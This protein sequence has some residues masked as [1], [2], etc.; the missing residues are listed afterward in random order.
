MTEPN[1]AVWYVLTLV[2]P[3]GDQDELADWIRDRYGVE[4]VQLV[5]PYAV[6]TW[7]E[8]YWDTPAAAE[9]AEQYIGSMRPD[10]LGTRVRRCDSRDWETFW[11]LHFKAHPVGERLYIQPVWDNTVS[12]E[13]GRTS[14]RI[15]PGLSFGTGEHFTTRF[16]L[17]MI[18]QL[19][20]RNKEACRTM[21]D[22]GC[23]SGILAVAAAL[24]GVNE[25]VGTDN[26]A[27]CLVQAAE[28]AALNGVTEQTGWRLEELASTVHTQ[29]P[30]P[31]FDVVCANLF[32]SLLLQGAPALWEATGRYLALSG[33]REHEVDTV[34][35]TFLR[36]GAVELVRDGDGD[37]A[38]LLFERPSPSSSHP[39][40]AGRRP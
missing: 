19:T 2:L 29:C 11:Q 8:I 30:P 16:C 3:S 14:L 31:G 32:A 28:N 13:A 24:L 23:G 15:V 40:P 18:D 26:D 22:V 33:I 12:P 10:V 4:P 1:T 37:W 20:R 17:E 34:A 6:H 27:L 39:K 25:V 35:E 5:R 38:G 21:W 7:L 36:A 9:A